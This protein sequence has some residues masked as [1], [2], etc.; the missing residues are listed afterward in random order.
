[1]TEKEEKIIHVETKEEFDKLI[2]GKAPVLVDF[3]AVWCGPCSV[4]GPI[5]EKI[6]EEYK[7]KIIFAKANVND[8]FGISEKVPAPRPSP[9]SR[10][11]AAVS[12]KAGTPDYA[13][14]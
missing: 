12:A 2:A 6:S 10:V 1:M 9:S 4:L 14:A 3:F 7:N 5:L 11:G 13:S 8:V